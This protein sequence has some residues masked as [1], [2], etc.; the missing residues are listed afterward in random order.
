M[1][2]GKAGARVLASR[3][4]ARLVKL[5]LCDT[6]LGDTGLA[7]LA[8]GEWPELERQGNDLQAA[9]ALP[10]NAPWLEELDLSRN[11]FHV[12]AAAPAL[13]ALSRLAHLRRLKVSECEL[14]AAGFKALAEAACPALTSLSA[15]HTEVAFDGPLALGAGA[16]AGFPALEELVLVRVPLGEAG[17]RLLARRRWARL[18]K[19]NLCVARL[20]DAGVA[21]L[22]LG[23]WPVLERLFLLQNRL[24]APPTL[25][26]AHHWAPALVELK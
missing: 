24:S 15:S 18:K 19:L 20:D 25:E 14:S 7:A 5:N 23:A 26:E 11:D 1:S 10:A 4:W 12:A 3:S 8:L 22:A 13:A 9:P 16:F 17:A 21:A 2:L 6:R